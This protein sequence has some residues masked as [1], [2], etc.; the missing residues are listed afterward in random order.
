MYLQVR[1]WDW[2]WNMGML[3]GGKVNLYTNLLSEIESL[4]MNKNI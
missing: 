3:D 2:N 1:V 4:R